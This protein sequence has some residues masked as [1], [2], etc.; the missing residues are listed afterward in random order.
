MA[1]LRTKL[2]VPPLHS[3]LIARPRLLRRIEDG[4]R[5]GHGL[6]LL[7]AP[8]GF[9]K[10]TLAAAWLAR[11]GVP[12]AAQDG[13]PQPFH[14]AWLSLDQHDNDPIRFWR[15][16]IAALQSR[17]PACGQ[18]ALAMLESAAPPALDA[19]AAALANDLAAG[20]PLVLA[21][22]DYHAIQSG[23]IHESLS[24]LLDHRPPQLHLLIT[25][26]EDPPLALARRRAR[27]QLT[28]VRAAELRFTPEEAA[29]F[30][31]TTMRLPLSPAD[32]AALERRTEGWIVGLHMAALSLQGRADTAA[33][34]RSFAGDDRYVSD[35]LVEEVLQRQP[36]E[37]QRFLLETSPLER[38]SGPLCDAVLDE[39]RKTKDESKASLVFAP[40]SLALEN[41]ERANLFVVPLDDRREWYRYHALFADLLRKRLL[42]SAGTARVAAIH[43]RASAWFA[44]AGY[45]NEAIGHALAAADYPRAVALIAG[46]A[47]ACF[48]RSEL[49][50]LLEWLR[51]LPDELRA[52]RPDLAMIGGWAAL[53][54]GQLDAAEA[55]MQAIER[56][57]GASIDA[58][59]APDL[60]RALRGPLTEV[61]VVRTSL[62]FNRFDLPLIRRLAE[63]AMA[64]LSAL[65]GDSLVGL[66]NSA[67]Q[68]L[69]VV[70]FNLALG[71]ELSGDIGAAGRTFV[72]TVRLAQEQSNIHIYALAMSHL[73]QMQAAQGRLREAAATCRQELLRLEDMNERPSPFAGMALAS[74]GSIQYE[75]NDLDRARVSLERAVELA[76]VWASWEGMLIGVYGLARLHA[77]RGDWPAAL[78]AMDELAD[79]LEQ[80]RQ[81]AALPAALALRARICAECG[82]LEEAAAWARACGIR[83]EDDITYMRE[84]ESII[85]AR[86]LLALGRHEDAGRLLG[87]LLM[88]AEAGERRGRAIELLALQARAHAAMG[89]PAAA[90]E[91]LAR[92]LRMAEPEGYARIFVDEGAPMAALLRSLK[93]EVGSTKSYLDQLLR[94]FE[95]GSAAA[96]HLSPLAAQP[97]VEPLSQRER[98][99]L[100][101]I[102]AGL[103]NQQIAV[104]LII[105]LTTVKTHAAN[106]FGKLGVAS[107]TQA[108]AEARVLGLLP[109]E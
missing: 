30:L 22:D 21:L 76:R 40:S 10:T 51:A 27:M 6:T 70:S 68:L 83:A 13:A 23:A 46:H 17:A 82:R 94:A 43:L 67:A 89:E 102:A 8:A 97:L 66:F 35:Y 81:P 73:A 48:E 80:R 106:I 24:F 61:L 19:V 15:Y 31:T 74:L 33:F 69:P 52:A 2:F 3:S 100:A 103:S 96:P 71:Q 79:L 99:V 56:A 11:D 91:A 28:E 54:T 86:V 107:R 104:R 105:S 92:A 29:D 16:L 41:L 20:E 109:R 64:Q 18:T 63:R 26:R 45:P 44:A 32:V 59:D 39:G 87:R 4:W 42:Q 12:E 7:A 93:D 38:L 88:A 14:S 34:V 57:L 25:T 65:A 9:G 101:L 37:L 84:G 53:A 1:L 90:R 60:P 85:L 58:L 62:A 77:A 36:P 49:Y 108:V 95:I 75:W 50:V 55:C 98:E 72:E 47:P 78:A 5:R